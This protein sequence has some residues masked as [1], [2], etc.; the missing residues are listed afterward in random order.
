MASTLIE[1]KS[2]MLL[3]RDPIF[4]GDEAAEDP[5]EELVRQLLEHQ[6]FKNAAQ[7]LYERT[8]VENAIFTRGRIETDEANSEVNASVFD[9]LTV[10][11]KILS[12]HREVVE[13]EIEREEVSLADM[14]KRMRKMIFGE[15]ELKLLRFLEELPSRREIVTAFI[16]ILEIIRTDSVKVYQTS[17]FG[18]IVVRPA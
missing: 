16:A 4:E 13:M 11:Q 14:V 8:T 2:K 6:K 10:F 1:I 7:M 12:R 3:P 17:T 15:K 5:R 9:I 18:E